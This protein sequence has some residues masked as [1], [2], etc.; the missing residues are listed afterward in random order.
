MTKKLFGN[1]SEY[2]VHRG[3]TTAYISQLKQLGRLVFTEAGEVD[4]LLSDRRVLMY[5]D[6]GRDRPSLHRH[7]QRIIASTTS[8]TCTVD[9]ITQL[10]GRLLAATFDES[11]VRVAAILKNDFGCTSEAA[12]DSGISVFLA[13]WDGVECSIGEDVNVPRIGRFGQSWEDDQPLLDEIDRMASQLGP[14]EF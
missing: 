2:A 3:C 1:Q 11:M 4:F 6:P 7:A 8:P 10:T 14:R 13:L 5:S 9:Q 12:L